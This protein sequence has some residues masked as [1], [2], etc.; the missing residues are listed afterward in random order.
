MSTRHGLDTENDSQ[1]GKSGRIAS[2][3]AESIKAATTKAEREE[4][5][6]WA[7][8]GTDSV[9]GVHDEMFLRLIADVERLEAENERLRGICDP[10]L[11]KLAE[12]GVVT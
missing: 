12:E 10:L 5:R 3:A 11:N 1:L 9:E 2:A 7:E 6:A 4:W 8:E